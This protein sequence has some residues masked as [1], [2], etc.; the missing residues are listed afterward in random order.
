MLGTGPEEDALAMDPN[1]E[2]AGDPVAIDHDGLAAIGQEE[3]T[4]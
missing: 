1:A 2:L 3:L 4:L